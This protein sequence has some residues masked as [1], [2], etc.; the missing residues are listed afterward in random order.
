MNYSVMLIRA[1]LL[2]IQ[3]LCDC[4][5]ALAY[6]KERVTAALLY[7]SLIVY[8]DFFLFFIAG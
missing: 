8:V 5:C 1:A 4:G 3:Q 6:T 7:A 2:L